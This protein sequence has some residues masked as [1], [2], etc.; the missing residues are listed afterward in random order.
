MDKISADIIDEPIKFT[1]KSKDIVG[2]RIDKYLTRAFPNYSRRYIQTL[3][4]DGAVLLNGK[5]PVNSQKLKEDDTVF[6][7]LPNRPVKLVLEAEDLKLD[8]VFEDDDILIINKRPGMVVHPADRY[9]HITGTVVNAVLFHCQNSLSGINGVLRPGIVHRLDKDTSGLM[10]VAKTDRAHKHMAKLIKERSIQK[11]YLALVK[12][13][14]DV[15]SGTINSPI[16]RDPIHRF[17][18]TVAGI[19]PKDALTH[20][21]VI[22]TFESKITGL[23]FSLLRVKIITGRTHQIRV[24]F[25]SIGHP[26]VGDSMYGEESLNKKVAEKFGLKRQFLHALI[27]KFCLPAKKEV[28]EFRASPTKDLIEFLEAHKISESVVYKTIKYIE[29]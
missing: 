8:I 9:R 22:K 11:E 19:E 26:I 27:L 25:S 20:F 16:G 10:I 5:R 28:S 12:G 13:S 29:G 23:T 18:K 2:D 24:H 7:R 1:I 3:I 14:F 4:D 6:V 21:V 17:R 15:E